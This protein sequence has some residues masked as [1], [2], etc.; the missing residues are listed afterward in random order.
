MIVCEICNIRSDDD[1]TAVKDVDNIKYAPD[2]RK[3]G[4][5]TGIKA[6]QDQSIYKN[7]KYQHGFY[8]YRPLARISVPVVVS[9]IYFTPIP[10]SAC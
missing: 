8:T 4:G 7:L 9:S 2:E 5:D 3:S 10:N 1:K 6:T